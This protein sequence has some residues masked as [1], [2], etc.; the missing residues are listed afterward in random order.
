MSQNAFSSAL[1]LG[2]LRQAF[3]TIFHA[4]SPRS[5]NTVG[6]DDTS[7]NDFR[8][9]EKAQLNRLARDIRQRR[10]HFDSLRPHLIPKPNDKY[11]LVCVPTVRD[12]VVQRALLDYLAERYADKLANKI[13]YGFIK[14][15][16]VKKAVVDACKLR[17][18]HPWVFKTDITSFFDRIERP[19]LADALRK[20]IRERSLHG[21]LLG[22]LSCEIQTVKGSTGKR[23]RA[24]GIHHG[25]GVRQGMPLSP[26]FSN[27]MLA[28]FDRSI[29][30]HG[31]HAVRYADDLIFFADSREECEALAQYCAQELGKIGLEIPPVD[32]GT[33]SVIY[34]PEQAAEFLG[35][36]LAPFGAGYRVELAVSQIERVRSSLLALGSLNELV[37][38]RITLPKLGHVLAVRKN[39]YLA[40]Y[41]MCQNVDELE[42]GLADLEQRILKKI[43]Q[44]GLHINLATLSGEARAFLGLR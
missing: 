8:A 32:A 42:R 15:R 5:R 38:R 24:L 35:V 44:E 18:S 30:A 11:R 1:S 20:I 7:I 25:R 34:A 31:Y 40:A 21:V 10:F 28:G 13:S 29:E 37:S 33:K 2:S 19:R 3:G 22:A 41:D 4:A 6:V 14:Q 17:T 9:D 12:R 27:I 16:G 36:S 23:I 26:F 39:G 43:Y